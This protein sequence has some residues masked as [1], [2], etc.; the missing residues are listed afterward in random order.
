MITMTL[1]QY[2]QYG[3]LRSIGRSSELAVKPSREPACCCKNSF[4]NPQQALQRISCS[5]IVHQGDSLVKVNPLFSL[6]WFAEI[7]FKLLDVVGESEKIPPPHCFLLKSWCLR[8]QN[9]TILYPNMF[10]SKTTKTQKLFQVKSH[11]HVWWN[12]VKPW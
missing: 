5:P 7:T 1:D 3:Y 6:F 9:L 2:R 11:H 12:M 4:A 8:N 10:Q